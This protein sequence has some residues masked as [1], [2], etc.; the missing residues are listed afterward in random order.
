LRRAFTEIDE[1]NSAI[2]GADQH[3]SATAEV[4]R[5]RMCHRQREPDGYGGVHGVATF[6][7]HCD[8]DIGGERLLSGY[9][10]M[11]CAHGLTGRRSYHQRQDE[12]ESRATHQSDSRTPKENRLLYGQPAF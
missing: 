11:R 7:H 8:T 1:R 12:G 5:R 2:R 9:D 4:S 3:E 10:A 6:L